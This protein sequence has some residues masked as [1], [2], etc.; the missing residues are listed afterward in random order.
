MHL[1]IKRC[2]CWFKADT[3]ILPDSWEAYSCLVCRVVGTA[4]IQSFLSRKVGVIHLDHLDERS[5]DPCKGFSISVQ[6]NPTLWYGHRRVWS[7]SAELSD[8]IPIWLCSSITQKTYVETG[9]KIN[10]F[11]WWFMYIFISIYLSKILWRVSRQNMKGVTSLV[12]HTIR[13]HVF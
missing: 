1:V 12:T 7:R 8:Y 11:V 3:K 10:D 9:N 2:N 5:V 4:H 13:L 6:S